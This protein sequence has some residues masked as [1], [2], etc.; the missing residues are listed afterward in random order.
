MKEIRFFRT[1]KQWMEFFISIKQ[2]KMYGEVNSF[3]ESFYWI[4]SFNKK[5]SFL[6]LYSNNFRKEFYY[7]IQR[8]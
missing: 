3:R 6:F 7:I 1:I 4:I 8:L 5:F 2:L